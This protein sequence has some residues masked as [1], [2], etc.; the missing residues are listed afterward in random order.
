MKRGIGIVIVQALVFSLVFGAGLFAQ[1][2]QDSKT[3][4]DRVEGTVR[5]INKDK[6][7]LTIQQAGTV[8]AAWQV[9]YNE[10]T[11]FT[12]RN[13]PAS[14]DQVKEGKRVI[15]LGKAEGANSL[16]ATRIDMRTK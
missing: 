13:S 1:L 14:L 5:S 16:H 6:S 10:Q 12:Y 8:K 2:R 7:T 4:L 15:C 9:T 3:K 11:K